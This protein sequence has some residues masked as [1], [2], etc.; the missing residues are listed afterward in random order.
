MRRTL[1]ILASTA[2]AMSTVALAAPARAAENIPSGGASFP[3][4][5]ISQCAADFNASQNNFTIQYTSTGSGTGKG[6]FAKGTFVTAMTDSAYTS[7]EPTWSWEY[8]PAIGGAITVPI[9]LKNAKTG[10]TLGSSIQLKQTT[11]AKIFGGAITTWNHPEIKKDNPRIATA[12]PA[13]PI[14]ISYRSDSSGTTNNFLQYLNAWAP[15]IFGKVQDDMSTAFPGGKPPSNSVA[16]RGNSG[17]M[18]NVLAKEGT[19]GYVDLGD[20]KGYPSARIQN[21]LG[22]FVAP[23][24]ASAAK[25]LANQTNVGSNGLVQLNYKNRVSGAYPIAI[26]SYA[27]ARTDGKGPN[28]LG[29]RQFWDYVLAKCGPSRAASL[30]YVPV[31]GKVL[32]KARQLVQLIK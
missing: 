28:G 30:G 24:A 11:L 31:A 16:G 29:V 23:S 6:N 4:V 17:V 19:I 13:T 10:R 25:N 32:A 14:T 20:A 7:G 18:A 8:I 22:E 9:N 12:L 26:F 27:L 1:A 15:S 3:Y 2:V 5:F 21:A